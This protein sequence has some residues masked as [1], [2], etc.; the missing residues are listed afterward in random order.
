[1]RLST[2]LLLLVV[3][4]FLF[5]LFLQKR[6]ER[7][8]QAALLPYRDQTAE[9]IFTTLDQALALTYPD[10]APLQDALK[11]IR[12]LSTGPRLPAGIPIYVDP[13]G[14]ATAHQT[15]KS[16]VKKPRN[17]NLTLRKHLSEIL[18][19]LGL[20]FTIRGRILMITTENVVTLDPEDD[21]Y[22]GFRDV[23]Q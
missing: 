7:E 18:K 3:F 2:L 5:G 11:N 10:G 1:M 8:L 19:S 14:L 21:P 12:L 15:M 4:A 9:A 13:Y 20:A 22:L 16:P 17:Q 6:R 23:L